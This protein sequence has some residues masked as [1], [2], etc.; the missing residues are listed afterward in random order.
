M[1]YVTQGTVQVERR[2]KTEADIFIAPTPDYAVKHNEQE[3]IVFVDAESQPPQSRL[4][5]TKTKVCTIQ[6]KTKGFAIKEEHFIE[7]LTEAAFK[8]TRI[9]IR[10]NDDCTKIEAIKIPAMLDRM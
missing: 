5:E 1:S 3:Y 4:F 8:T 7:M 9:E 10:M 6:K 2:T